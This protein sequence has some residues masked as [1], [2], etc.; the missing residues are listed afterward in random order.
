VTGARNGQTVKSVAGAPI[1]DITVYHI[2]YNTVGGA[3]EATVASGA[4][5]VPSGSDA[6]CSGPRPIVLYA[7]AT[8]T[9]RSFNIADLGN[10]GN[11]EGLLLAAFFAARGDIVVAPNY[12]GYDTSTL[13]YHPFLVAAGA[14]PAVR[15]R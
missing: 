1:C 9:D 7:H 13:P 12:A 8:T 10:S 3:G 4:L 6:R 2:E 11:A 15:R 14:D 5:M